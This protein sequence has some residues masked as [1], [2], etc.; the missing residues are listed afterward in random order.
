M[1]IVFSGLGNMGGPMAANLVA[2]GETVHGYDPAPAAH[3]TDVTRFD[4]ASAAVAAADVVVTML[5]SGKHVADARQ[6]AE[7][8]TTAGHH[9]RRRARVQRCGRRRSRNADVG[10]SMIAV[11]EAFA[12]G[13]ELGL[14]HQA[15]FGVAST[16]SGQ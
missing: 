2:S 7:L 6:A 5:P 15:L 10:V 3:S 16:A 9:G 1:T 11:S 12:L 4:S 14:T 13:E 8:V